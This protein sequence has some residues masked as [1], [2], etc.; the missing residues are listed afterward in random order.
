[1]YFSFIFLLVSCASRWEAASEQNCRRL[2]SQAGLS[3]AS[4]RVSRG[5]Y[6][7]S[8]MYGRRDA[9][10][11]PVDSLMRSA[12]GGTPP[13]RAA[14]ESPSSSG[15]VGRAGPTHHHGRDPSARTL[16][17]FSFFL[18]FALSLARCVLCAYRTLCARARGNAGQNGPDE[19]RSGLARV[20]WE[21]GP[22]HLVS[23]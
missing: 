9:L 2:R 14:R 13:G 22:K 11:L 18:F 3:A 12:K 23:D 6:V 19:T 7:P 16:R 21:R 10:F 17:D 8:A 20:Q 15:S 1:M 5:S 4:R